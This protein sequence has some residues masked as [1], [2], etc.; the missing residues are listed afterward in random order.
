MLEGGP[1]IDHGKRIGVD[2]YNNVRCPELKGTT[3]QH[4]IVYCAVNGLSLATIRGKVVRH[5]C[6][7][8]RCVNPQHL[9]IG[10]HKENTADMYARG[11]NIQVRG[12]DHPMSKLTREMVTFIRTNY[13]AGHKEF[14]CRALARRFGVAHPQISRIIHGETYFGPS[15]TGSIKGT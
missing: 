4:R 2:T 9:V 13:I 3:T 12:V 6:D 15:S 8:R 1:C 7:N 5:T 14:G 11:R 10:T